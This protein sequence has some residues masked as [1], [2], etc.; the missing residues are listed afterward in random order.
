[1]PCRSDH[2]D[3]APALWSALL[4][5]IPG[6][7]EAAGFV[8][9]DKSVSSL[10]Y[11]FAGT[12]ALAEDASSLY[13]NPAGL[14]HLDGR[15]LSVAAH[16]IHSEVTY[17]EQNSNVAGPDSAEISST[18]LA[19]NFYFMDA[20][21]ADLRLGFGIYAPF[22]TF[23]DYDAD[24]RGRYHSLYTDLKVVNLSP[25]LAWRVNDRVSVGMTVDAQYL[26]ARLEQAVDF[27]LICVDRLG[28]S[29][30]NGL[31]LQPGQDDG[32]QT[33][34]GDNLA[35]GYSLGITWDAS[36]ATRLGATYH[37]DVRHD[38]EGESDFSGVPSPFSGVFSDS[39][40]R[41]AL[42]LPEVV[43]L[44]LAHRA[45]PSLTLLADATWTRWSRFQELRVTFDNGLPDA[46][47]PQNWQDVWRFG[48]GLAWDVN[49]PWRLRLGVSDEE[50][51]VPD[52]EHRGARSPDGPRRIYAL[53]F[54]YAPSGN[55]SLDASY[56]RVLL[57][58]MGVTAVDA[59]GHRLEGQYEAW[60]ELLSVQGNWRF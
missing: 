16:L 30:C 55:F 25:A 51:T 54:N 1:M 49:E 14:T 24:W 37:S 42:H 40:G 39:G 11:A 31:G 43:S 36:D 9:S 10:G 48:L 19:P 57:P 32:T 41:V 8:V 52:R 22:G 3:R 4:L 23:S 44:G 5:V 18:T 6:M 34:D 47:S 13:N 28:V 56:A 26:D 27:G 38:I 59:Q 7:A 50:G 12:A 2:A 45:S 58:G 29:T 35:V 53:G 33:L 46:V 15:R 21:T 20:P 60:G 17:H